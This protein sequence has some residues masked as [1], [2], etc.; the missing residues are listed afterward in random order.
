MLGKYV[1]LLIKFCNLQNHPLTFFNITQETN[2]LG[3]VKVQRKLTFGESLVC[4]RQFKT[5]SHLSILVWYGTA[6]QVS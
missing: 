2:L 1:I 6:S 3:R 4:A 5:L